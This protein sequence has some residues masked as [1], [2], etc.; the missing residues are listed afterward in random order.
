MFE[1]IS[2]ALSESNGN[3]SS[4]RVPFWVWELVLVMSFVAAVVYAIWS[5]FH[6]PAN[7]FDPK[8]LLTW[9]LA[10]FGANRTSKAVQ[11]AQESDALSPQF[12][13]PPQQ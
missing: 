6:N 11:K 4:L 1:W 3:P 8:G 2:R 13:Q 7:A 10:F 9:I 5:H 12:Q